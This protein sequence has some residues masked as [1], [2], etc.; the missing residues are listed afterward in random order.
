MKAMLLDEKRNFVWSQVADP[1]AK[2]GSL[3]IDVK[4]AAVNR[5]DLLQ[6]A[7]TYPSPEGWPEWM[8]LE[9]AGVV[10]AVGSGCNRFKV[11]DQVCA[12]LGGGGY[13]EKVAVPEDMVMPMPDGLSFVEAA[14]LPEV[15]ATCYLNLFIEGEYKEGETLFFPAAASGLASAGIPM[16]KAFG[17]Y[18]ITSVRDTPTVAKVKNLGADVIIDS[19]REDVVQ[20]LQREAEKGH[21]VDVAIDCLAG[22]VIGAAFN[23]VHQGCRW[24]IVST[25]AGTETTV[26]LRALLTRGIKLKGSMLRRRTVAEKKAIL[27]SLVAKVWPKLAD[28]SIVPSIYKVLPISRAEEAHAILEQGLSV[29]KVVLTVE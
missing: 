26:P 5:A 23:N 16:A 27:D 6:R 22:E 10:S 14:S 19:S 21:P 18:V 28:K 8:G 29:G 1:V 7:G 24:V 20:V 15:Y 11:G 4:A 17:A 12:L 3:V 2:A 9:V 13:A 25:L